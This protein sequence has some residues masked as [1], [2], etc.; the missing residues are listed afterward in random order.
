MI[1][2][3]ENTIGTGMRRVDEFPDVVGVSERCLTE[4]NVNG[5]CSWLTIPGPVRHRQENCS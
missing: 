4:T 2:I 3:V 5:W 1:S